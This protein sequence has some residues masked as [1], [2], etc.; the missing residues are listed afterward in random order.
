MNLRILDPQTRFRIRH[1]IR[2]YYYTVDNDPWLVQWL[3]TRLALNVYALE[4]LP[5]VP[6]LEKKR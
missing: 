2:W 1:Y 5:P 4:H 6:P 3:G